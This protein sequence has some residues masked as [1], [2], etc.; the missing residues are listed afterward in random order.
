MQTKVSEVT[1]QAACVTMLSKEHLK[2]SKRKTLFQVF[3]SVLVVV[4]PNK[5]MDPT[6]IDLL[7]QI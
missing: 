4:L 3:F 6:H 7:E 1:H 5:L 2:N